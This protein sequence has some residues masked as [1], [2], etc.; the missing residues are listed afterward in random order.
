MSLEE[1]FMLKGITALLILSVGCFALAK[2]YKITRTEL[3][4]RIYVK[5]PTIGKYF[6]SKTLQMYANKQHSKVISHEFSGVKV[7][8]IPFMSDNFAYLIKCTKTN[9]TALVDCGDAKAVLNFFKTSSEE[10]NIKNLHTILCTHKHHDHC[11]GNSE[12][13]SNVSSIK[14]VVSGEMEANCE[15]SNFKVKDGQSIYVGEVEVQCLSTPVHTMGSI[16]YFLPAQNL[17]FTGDYLFGGGVGKFFEGSAVDFCDSVKRMEKVIN[18]ETKIFPGH[19]Y[20]LSNLKFAENVFPSNREIKQRLEVVERMRSNLLPTCPFTYAD[21]LKT[22]VFLLCLAKKNNEELLQNIETI[23]NKFKPKVQNGSEREDVVFI[24]A[25]N[26][27]SRDVFVK[28][29]RTMKDYNLTIQSLAK[30]KM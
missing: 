23:I 1:S 12:L 3:M 5:F 26:N 17:L 4:Y 28:A 27:S 16:S 21:E 9:Q 30:Q 2:K 11:G 22:N 10:E 19:E 25:S 13:V 7:S 15:A 29:L 18:E 14:T 24:D 6:H 20:T 8:I